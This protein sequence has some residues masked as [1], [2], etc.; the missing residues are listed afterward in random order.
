MWRS[1]STAEAS[2]GAKRSACPELCEAAEYQQDLFL[3]RHG[4]RNKRI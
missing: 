1:P 3:L 2:A 4:C